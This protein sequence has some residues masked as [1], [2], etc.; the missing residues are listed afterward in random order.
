MKVQ[1]NWRAISSDLLRSSEPQLTPEDVSSSTHS[2]ICT[3]V[4]SSLPTVGHERDRGPKVHVAPSR[5]SHP[6]LF[7]GTERGYKEDLRGERLVVCARYC[8]NIL[9]LDCDKNGRMRMRRPSNFGWKV[10]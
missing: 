2:K 8:I 10:V 6:S 3:S 9:K 1:I 5:F 7:H 4:L